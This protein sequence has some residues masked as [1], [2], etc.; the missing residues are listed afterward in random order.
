M[1]SEQ[2]Q[3]N[4]SDRRSEQRSVAQRYY[5]VEFTTSGL[6]AFYRFKLWNISLSGMCILVK[7]D[8]EVLHHFK[9][10]D[11]LVMTY[12]LADSPAA[13]ENLKTQIKHITK[14]EDGRFKG[15]YLVGLSILESSQAAGEIPA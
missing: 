1:S 5:S 15:H 10:G 13:H 8:S 9:I 3:Q 4:S 14:N 7:E 11:S 12:Y 2:T 6:T